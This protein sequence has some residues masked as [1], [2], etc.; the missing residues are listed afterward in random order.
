MGK[1]KDASGRAG[2]DGIIVADRD[3]A[4]PIQSYTCTQGAL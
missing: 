3:V 2:H 4:V 1:W